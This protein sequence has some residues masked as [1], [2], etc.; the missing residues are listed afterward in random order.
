[1]RGH[2]EN[3]FCNLVC[4]RETVSDCKLVLSVILLLKIACTPTVIAVIECLVSHPHLSSL[5]PCG[6]REK[7][8]S[9]IPVHVIQSGQRIP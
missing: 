6:K 5:R 4:V 1:M 3:I 7:K 8:C 2:S 9:C